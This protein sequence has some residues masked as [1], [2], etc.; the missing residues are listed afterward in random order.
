MKWPDQ[1]RQ[2]DGRRAALPHTQSTTCARLSKMITVMVM[3]VTPPGR[4]LHHRAPRFIRWAVGALVTATVGVA[5]SSTLLRP[6]GAPTAQRAVVGV[7][8]AENFWGNI[9]SQ[10]GGRDV[11]VT[12]LITNPKA[13]AH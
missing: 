6:V 5:T 2:S 4:F 3:E 10:L 1:P 9:A 12:S 8:A 13:D 11:S 7:V